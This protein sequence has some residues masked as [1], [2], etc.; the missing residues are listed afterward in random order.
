M[1]I[2]RRYI[3]ELLKSIKRSPLSSA[4]VPPEKRD[5][6]SSHSSSTSLA[7][8]TG[9]TITLDSSHGHDEGESGGSEENQLLLRGCTR[10]LIYVMVHRDNQRCPLCRSS[11]LLNLFHD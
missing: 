3:P 1:K 6:Y 7:S 5:M 4:E 8:S 9:S 11:E 2:K 10:C